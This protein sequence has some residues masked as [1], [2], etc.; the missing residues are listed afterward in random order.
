MSTDFGTDFDWTDDVPLRDTPVNGLK[1]LGNA[2]CR[3]LQTPRGALAFIGD[4]P[5]YG[6]DIRSIVGMSMTDREVSQWQTAI[7]HEC[8]KDERVASADVALQFEFDTQ[9]LT[10]TINI[11]T[12]DDTATLVLT[13]TS[14]TVDLLRI[15]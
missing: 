2:L 13:A 9:T 6:L 15:S 11:T 4:D 8:E 1:N 14:V 3:R 10:I 5:D 12:A 7:A